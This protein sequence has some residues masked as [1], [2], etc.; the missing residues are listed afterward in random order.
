[1]H[2][3]KYNDHFAIRIAGPG[4]DAIQAINDEDDFAIVDA[5][6]NKIKK[7]VLLKN[8]KSPDIPKDT[9]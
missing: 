7:A 4:I 3:L 9:P 1:M 2:I 5:M 6:L 8:E